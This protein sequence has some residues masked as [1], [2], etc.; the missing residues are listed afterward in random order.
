LSLV[1]VLDEPVREPV[2]RGQ[3]AL[4]HPV[5]DDPLERAVREVRDV[6]AHRVEHAVAG[7]EVLV[8]HRR[9]P[10]AEPVVDVRDEP[11]L[12]VE[13]GVVAAVQFLAVAI[14]E[15]HAYRT[16]RTHSVPRLGP[17]AAARSL[18]G[19]ERSSAARTR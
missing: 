16:V 5:T 18:T 6:T 17:S 7:R 1:E 8:V 14:V 4:V 13:R 12:R 2:V 10:V 3:F 19:T 15:D 11:R 9:E